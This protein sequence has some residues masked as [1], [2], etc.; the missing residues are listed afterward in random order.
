[1]TFEELQK[2]ANEITDNKQ[3]IAQVSNFLL[4]VEEFRVQLHTLC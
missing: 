1:M 4:Q 3:A 2:L